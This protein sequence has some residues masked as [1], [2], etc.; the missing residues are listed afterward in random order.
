MAAKQLDLRISVCHGTR[1]LIVPMQGYAYVDAGFLSGRLDDDGRLTGA[2]RTLLTALTFTG[3]PIAARTVKDASNPWR[4]T[5]GAYEGE[6]RIIGPGFEVN[7]RIVATAAKG[8]VSMDLR[9]NIDGE[10]PEIRSVARPFQE[11]IIQTG[12][13]RLTGR[14]IV[15]FSTDKKDEISC[16][17]VTDYSLDCIGSFSPV[18]RNITIDS[19]CASEGMSQFEQIDLFG[20]REDA[21]WDLEAKQRAR[22]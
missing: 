21:I 12:Q 11:E 15:D 18:W 19:A 6:R 3:C 10:L 8:S 5:D 7:S 9:V 16:E 14:F 2:E 22:A 17:A 4:L 13:G 20:V 1:N